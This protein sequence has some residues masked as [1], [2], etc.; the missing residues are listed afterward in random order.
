MRIR[1]WITAGAAALA[2]L[3]FASLALAAS[4]PVDV[5]G[6]SPFAACT[7]GGPGTNYVNSEV[8]PFVAVNPTNP[9]NIV[10]VFQQDRWSN[11]GAHGLVASTSHDGGS[12]WTQRP[13]PPLDFELS[14]EFRGPSE[15]WSGV[16][17]RDR[18]YVYMSTDAGLTWQTRDLPRTLDLPEV[19]F[20]TSVRIL[21]GAGVLAYVFAQADGPLH[22]YASFD[23]GT[24]WSRVSWPTSPGDGGTFFFEDA[25]TWWVFQQLVLYKTADSG[26]T[27][28]RVAVRT[29]T[30]PTQVQ[31]LDPLHAWGQIDDGTGVQLV[32][33][34]DGGLHW[35]PMNVPVVQ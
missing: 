35:T 25:A 23:A 6:L 33:T 16:A 20:L 29:S 10:G 26:R 5:S 2:I 19:G 31:V 7:V 15:G 22:T 27:W 9:S 34:S 18:A 24:T 14:T 8:E 17:A 13:D 30:A 21:P 12:T 28:T 3:A 11:G 4:G 1:R 32:T